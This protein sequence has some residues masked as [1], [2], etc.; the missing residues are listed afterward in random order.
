MG[1][2][3]LSMPGFAC[4]KCMGFLTDAILGKEAANYGRAANRS[5]VGWSNAILAATAVGI[6]VDLITD[7]SKSIR[8]PIFMSYDGNQRTMNP[9]ARLIYCPSV[10][11]H[12]EVSILGVVVRH[13]NLIA[14][15]CYLCHFCTAFKKYE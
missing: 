2:V 8:G 6:A 12:Y 7:W 15:P 9:D 11:P 3:I 4:M 13:N 1:Q 10:C 14:I 5:Q